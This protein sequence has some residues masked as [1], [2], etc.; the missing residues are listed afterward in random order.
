MDEQSLQSRLV[1]AEVKAAAAGKMADP[2]DAVH[3]LDIDDFE[4]DDNGRVDASKVGKAIDGLIQA[5]PYLRAQGSTATRP[6]ADGGARQAPAPGSDMNSILQGIKQ[7]T[8]MGQGG[9]K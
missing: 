4:V 9:A 5:K 1:A 6:T 7:R 2:E 3:L 8:G